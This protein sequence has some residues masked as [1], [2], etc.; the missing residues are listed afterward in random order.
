MSLFWLKLMSFVMWFICFI[1]WIDI[2]RK[3]SGKGRYFYFILAFT[4]YVGIMLIMALC[5]L[6]VTWEA[7]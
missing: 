3:Q 7:L 2:S 6:L 1:I 5:S 4:T